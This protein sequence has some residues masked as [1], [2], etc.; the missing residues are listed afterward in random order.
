MNVSLLVFD[1]NKSISFLKTLNYYKEF[2]RAMS[3]IIPAEIKIP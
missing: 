1:I 3:P 2:T